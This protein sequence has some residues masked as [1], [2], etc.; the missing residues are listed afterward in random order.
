M[1]DFD[2]LGRRKQLRIKAIPNLFSFDPN[3]EVTADAGVDG[4]VPDPDALRKR[5]FLRGRGPCCR[6]RKRR[7]EPDQP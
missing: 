6:D 5:E 2:R 7:R 3:D 1:R 4:L